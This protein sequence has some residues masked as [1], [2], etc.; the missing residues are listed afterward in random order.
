MCLGLGKAG[1]QTSAL[2]THLGMSG[3]T[4]RPSGT[5]AL[6]D[7]LFPSGSDNTHLEVCPLRVST[8]SLLDVSEWKRV[9]PPFSTLGA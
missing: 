8:Y 1:A 3:R 4:L 2:L 6:D 7:G 9:F 5:V